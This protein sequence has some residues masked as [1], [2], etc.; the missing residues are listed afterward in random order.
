M[1]IV[2]LADSIS[3]QSSGIHYYGTQ[4]VKRLLREFPENEYHIIA[5]E[6]IIE[7][8]NVPQTII[9]LKKIPFH[10]RLR[11]MFYFPKLVK[12]LKPDHVIEL[13]HFGPFGLSKKIKRTTV[14][15]D[16]T[17]LNYPEFHSTLSNIMHRL[18]LPKIIKNANSLIVN[19][20]STK[21]DLEKFDPNS[22][23]KISVIFPEIVFTDEP[24]SLKQTQGKYLLAVGTIEPRKN[25]ETLLKAFELVGN[26]DSKIN[27][28]IIGSM[29]WKMNHFA[30]LIEKHPHKDR[31]KITGYIERKE[32]QEYYKNA[33]AFVFPSHFEGFG[34]PIL[35]ACNYGL[36]MLLSDIPTSKEI[37][38]ES[39]IYFNANNPE[40]LHN[41]IMELIANNEKAIT[42]GKMSKRRFAELMK[43]A[44]FQL[45]EWHNKIN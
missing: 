43:T 14:I 38:K 37:A 4:L 27:L 21:I 30:D 39:A 45:E 18:L 19:S 34:I 5:T 15:H 42:L 31:I 29:G 9:K 1:K 33:F 32:L 17:P 35:E 28:I 6:K 10:L 40:E 24:N 25:Y 26:N 22:K 20:T 44:K 23:H 11:Q 8:N 3:T 41:G 7:F 12:N 13:A 2:I 36:P 16:L